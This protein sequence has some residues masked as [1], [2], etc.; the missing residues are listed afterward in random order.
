MKICLIRHGKTLGNLEKRYIGITDEPLCEIGIDELKRMQLPQSDLLFCSPMK[1][2]IQT[3][4][5]LFPSQKYTTLDALRE[6]DFG[7][8]EGKNCH[9]LTEDAVY[10]RWI[11]SGGTLAF[12]HGELPSDFRSRC[13]EEFRK[14]VGSVSDQT[15]MT[16]VV[17]GGTIMAILNQFSDPH[18]D[19]FDW[20]CENGH[21]Y[22]CEW[23]QNRLINMEEIY[24]R[25]HGKISIS[26][27]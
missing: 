22:F 15:S 1:R 14:I 26:F 2:C 17:H 6:C 11:D 10:Q 23:D 20:Y 5:I 4:E 16:F 12:P 27:G 7:D 3:A 21:G 18:R 24:T 9:D 13:A 8:F 25:L 19:Y